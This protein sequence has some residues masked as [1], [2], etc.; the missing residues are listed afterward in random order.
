MTAQPTHPERNLG[1]LLVGLTV[2][3]FG[4]TLFLDRAGLIDGF[5]YVPFWPVII[6]TVGLVKLSHP[7]ADG[8]REG[9]WWVFFGVWLLLNETRIIR[10]RDSWPLF[11]V[12]LGVAIVWK[13]FVRTPRAHER[14]E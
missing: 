6:V 1:G 3:L 2:M 9:G 8:R 12:A 13:E 14:V 4:A 11:L 10:F 7:R 5:Y